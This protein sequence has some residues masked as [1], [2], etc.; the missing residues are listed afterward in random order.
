MHFFHP[1]AEF[2]I[3]ARAAEHTYQVVAHVFEVPQASEDFQHIE[4]QFRKATAE[5]VALYH[6]IKDELQHRK[7]EKVAAEKADKK[8]KK[9]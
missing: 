1:V 2:G 9:K 6:Q 4:S 5:E 3:V 7:E 8:P